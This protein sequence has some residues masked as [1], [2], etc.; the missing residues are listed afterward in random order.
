MTKRESEE[1]TNTDKK[2]AKKLKIEKKNQQ[3]NETYRIYSIK[4]NKSSK[5]THI[6]YIEIVLYKHRIENT[7]RDTQ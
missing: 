1:E 3:H 4:K 6:I 7:T 2:W 5:N